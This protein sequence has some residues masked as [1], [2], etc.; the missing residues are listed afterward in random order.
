MV[1][2]GGGV[3][4]V[5]RRLWLNSTLFLCSMVSIGSEMG[6]FVLMVIVAEGMNTAAAWSFSNISVI[7]Q[8]CSIVL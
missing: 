7:S 2:G 4:W 6:K 5:C 3:G 8:F 1:G